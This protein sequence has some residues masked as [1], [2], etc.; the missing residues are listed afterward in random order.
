MEKM[1]KFLNLK[2]EEFQRRSHSNRTFKGKMFLTFIV[3]LIILKEN[4]LKPILAT[5]L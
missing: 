1:K 4:L 5:I 2:N 3:L